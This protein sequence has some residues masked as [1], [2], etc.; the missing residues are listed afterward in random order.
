MSHVVATD[1]DTPALA[2]SPDRRPRPSLGWW[3]VLA[4]ALVW[5]LSANPIGPATRRYASTMFAVGRAGYGMIAARAAFALLFR[6]R[7]WSWIAYLVL[8]VFVEPL[9]VGLVDQSQ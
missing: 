6:N 2:T 9:I 4:I 1:A 8:L 7:S 3:A 5:A